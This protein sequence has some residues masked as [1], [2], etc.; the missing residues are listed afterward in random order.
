MFDYFESDDAVYSIFNGK[1]L[2]HLK[3]WDSIPAFR[4]HTVE[5]SVSE[6]VKAYRTHDLHKGG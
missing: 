2:K 4:Y 1:H 3:A 6:Y 5:I